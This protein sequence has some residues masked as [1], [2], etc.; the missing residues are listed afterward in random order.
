MEVGPNPRHPGQAAELA[1]IEAAYEQRD[2]A[3][4][5]S[6]Y[7]FGNP[8]YAFFSEL[9]EQALLDALRRAPVELERA[10]V[11]D[12]GCG[13]GYFAHRLLE[14]GATTVT[15]VDLMPGRIEQARTRYPAVHFQQAN[16]AELPFPHA[17]FDLV[18]HFTCLSSVLDPALRSA[19]AA[20]MWRVLAP[21][22]AVVSYDIRP[23]TRAV[24]GLRVLGRWRRG[25]RPWTRE[26][27][28]TDEG[29][30]P[31]TPTTGIAE[32]EL[33]RLFPRATISYTSAG[34]AFGLTGIAARS[35]LAA[36][37]LSYLPALHEHA[38]AVI[39]R[40]RP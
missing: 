2:T 38:I 26:T 9:L 33:R 3:G 21:G 19:I 12:V 39:A 11:L 27:D 4:D 18:T 35:P 40:P 13:S 28:E 30:E 31:Q 25:E 6:P 34:L 23:A 29:R 7:R 32:S 22:G 5:E 36:R 8:G 17:S 20:E 16:A 1:R 37:A 15:G 24:R 10:A 14:F